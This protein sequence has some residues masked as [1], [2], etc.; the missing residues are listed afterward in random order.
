VLIEAAESS[1]RLLAPPESWTDALL[2]IGQ[3]EPPPE[4]LESGLVVPLGARA[5]LSPPLP[6]R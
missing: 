1:Q 2:A 5:A 3:G 4:L 6:G